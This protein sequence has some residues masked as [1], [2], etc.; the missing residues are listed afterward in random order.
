ME[1][2]CLFLGY[3]MLEIGVVAVDVAI[4]WIEGGSLR[5]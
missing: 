2:R 1:L 5:E 3:P 4:L